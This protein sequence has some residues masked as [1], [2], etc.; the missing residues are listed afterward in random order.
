MTAHPQ[1][2]A[3]LLQLNDRLRRESF[4][5]E[6]VMALIPLKREYAEIQMRHKR[7]KP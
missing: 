6:R 5:R 4:A 3:A 2:R 1:S 7:R